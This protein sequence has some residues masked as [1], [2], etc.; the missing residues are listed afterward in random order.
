MTLRGPGGRE[1]RDIVPRPA[2]EVD[3]RAAVACVLAYGELARLEHEVADASVTILA[4]AQARE[5]EERSA[6]LTPSRSRQDHGRTG[7]VN[8]GGRLGYRPR[9]RL[10]KPF[11]N[12]CE[13]RDG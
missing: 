3:D 11:G 8:L 4:A 6:V 12:G 10:C 5:G 2:P 9:R 1:R 13:Q 7:R